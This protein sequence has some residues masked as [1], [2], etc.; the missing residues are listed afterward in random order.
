MIPCCLDDFTVFD[1]AGRDGSR[2][3]WLIDGEM[4]LI[5][6]AEGL[7]FGDNTV[8]SVFAFNL[9][10]GLLFKLRAR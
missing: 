9:G 3:G 6:D 10:R 5:G 7:S 4:L 8:S 1:K 2:E